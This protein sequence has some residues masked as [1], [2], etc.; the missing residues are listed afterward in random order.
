MNGKMNPLNFTEYAE[1][2]M[3]RTVENSYFFEKDADLIYRALEDKLHPISFA[4]YL[5]RYIYEKAQLG[6]KYEDVAIE[7]FQKIIKINFEENGTPCS[8]EPTTAKMS[9]L[10]KNWLTQ[11]NVNR[12]V[13]FLLGFGL[14][15]TV[16]DVNSFLTK[17]IK[18]QGINAK[19]PF[20]I[21][22]WYC[23]KNR[24]S[25]YKFDELWKQ[26]RKAPFGKKTDNSIYQ[27]RTIGVRSSFNGIKSDDDLM[28]FLSRFKTDDNQ[29]RLSITT[30]E[31][32]CLLYEEA[33]TLIADLYNQSEEEKFNE[34]LDDYQR[35]L[36]HNEKIT[37]EERIR[38]L[39]H[40]KKERK[41]IQK[42]EITESDLEKVLCSAIPID[43]N[44]NLIS[45]KFSKLYSQFQGKRFS[46]QHINDILSN[47]AEINRF[48]L[49]T[50]N[51]FV[52]SQKMDDSY[53]P[54]DRYEKFVISTNQILE[55][56]SMGSLYMANP[57]ECF[58][59]MCILSVSPLSTY[60][61]VWEMSYEVKQ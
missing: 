4:D 41:Y 46:R 59:L 19:N 2:C 32:F 9:A 58:V 36:L 47:K 16:K 51:F 10:S 42:D 14:K 26:Y 7:E 30:R 24:Y 60:A 18:E 49:I 37:D 1:R 55:Q 43:R 61:D 35:E 31:N 54:K 52:Y 38:R 45:N 33:K 11:Q 25:Y 5:K 22:C 21:I 29:I 17:A 48:D 15:M 44:G 6:K 34:I 28:R 56:C 23:Y 39:D 12:K 40:K 50:L 27:D 53:D 57:Y 3:H 20:E 8:F 13:I